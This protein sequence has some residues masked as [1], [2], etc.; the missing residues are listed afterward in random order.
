LDGARVRRVAGA[1]STLARSRDRV[2][3]PCREVAADLVGPLVR[4]VHRAGRKADR[5]AAPA[6]HRLRIRT[7]SLRYSLETLH[8]VGDVKTRKLATRLAD[9]QRVLGEQRDADGQRAWLV[10]HVPAFVDDTEAL[11]AIGAL[12]EAFRRRAGCCLRRVPRALR[13]AQRPKLVA[14]MRHE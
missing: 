10:E 1:L 9:L 12:A 3:T 6:L 5:F 4:D 2:R 8:D 7:K 13:R 11:V 14:A